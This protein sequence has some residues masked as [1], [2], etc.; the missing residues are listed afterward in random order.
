MELP[1][2]MIH[3][4]IAD[5]IKSAIRLADS[6]AYHV[7]TTIFASA[8]TV[9]RRAFKVRVVARQKREFY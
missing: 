1:I 5:T 7:L 3:Q 6:S 2:A 4:R 9:C 8:Q